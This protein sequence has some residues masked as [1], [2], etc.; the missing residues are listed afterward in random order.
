MTGAGKEKAGTRLQRNAGKGVS[1]TMVN[2][3]R[4]GPYRNSYPT[5]IMA[6]VVGDRVIGHLLH[7]GHVGVEAFDRDDRSLGIFPTAAEAA[8]AIS[9][10]SRAA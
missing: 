4:R 2:L 3:E 6:V 10:T 7:R 1:L 5:S 9:K 8:A